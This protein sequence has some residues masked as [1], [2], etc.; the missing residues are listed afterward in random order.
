MRHR[1]VF[2]CLLVC[3][4]PAWAHDF[5]LKPDKDGAVLVY[6]HA[7]ENT[8]YERDVLKGVAGWSAQGK[9][10]KVDSAYQGQTL[11]LVA[12]QARTLAVDI[13]NR[14]WVKTVHG[15][16]HHS[17]REQSSYLKST[18]DLHYAKL[19]EGPD[20]TQ[21]VGH[22]LE[23]VLR[24]V[25]KTV[26]G[27][28]LLNGKPLPGAELYTEHKTVATANAQG[29]FSL[30]RPDGLLVLKVEHIE[31]LVGNPD[32]DTRVMYATLTLPAK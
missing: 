10:V 18:W 27:Q 20:Y 1:F 12:P 15:W 31:P 8:P 5:W 16:K 17:K 11:H 4:L 26:E 29:N 24:S 2:F 19:V 30:S 13:D 9:S 25:G 23:I 6:G 7:G 3:A 32:A 14:F 21:K 28:V 22:P